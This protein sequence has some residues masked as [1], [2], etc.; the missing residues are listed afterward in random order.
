MCK[1]IDLLGIQGVVTKNWNKYEKE[2]RD[3]GRKIINSE[4]SRNAY[5]PIYENS[6]ERF[7]TV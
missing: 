3:F 4:E 5:E 6:A 2:L 7:L 1:V